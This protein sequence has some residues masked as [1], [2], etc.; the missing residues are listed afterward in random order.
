MTEKIPHK[1][2]FFPRLTA[3]SISPA[4]TPRTLK[5][6]PTRGEP[7]TFHW[8]FED[9]SILEFDWNSYGNDG[10]HPAISDMYLK[11]IRHGIT[12]SND[13]KLPF[14]VEITGGNWK[15]ADELGP[16]LSVNP[17]EV[18]AVNGCYPIPATVISSIEDKAKGIYRFKEGKKIRITQIEAGARWS[19]DFCC[20][21]DGIHYTVDPEMR[22]GK[23]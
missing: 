3:Y 17:E 21:I 10:K 22:I 6:G 16:E 15:N 8:D 13:R 5:E 23:R 14:Q 1:I 11:F 2:T 19:F 12:K 18:N 7:E 4:S 9:Q 20:T